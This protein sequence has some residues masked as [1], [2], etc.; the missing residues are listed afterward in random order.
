M[1]ARSES[2]PRPAESIWAALAVAALAVLAF[3][4]SWSLLHHGFYKHSN[5]IDTPIYQ[6]YGAAIAR[7]RVP[8]R[9]FQLEYPPGA[10]PVFVLPALGE[11]EQHDLDA[12]NHA[13][14][15]LMW[16]CG[17]AVLV[18]MAATLRAVRASLLRI[19]GALAFAAVAP[20]A[21][22]PVVLSRFDLWPAALTAGAIAA[23]VAGRRLLALLML[24]LATTAKLYPAVLLP[25]ALVHVW[26][27][28][29]ARAAAGAATAFAAAI[30]AVSAPFVALSPGGVWHSVTAQ[31]SRPLQIESLGSS[32]LLAAHQVAGV[33]LTMVSSYGSQNLA[34]SLPDAF[35]SAQA[36]LLVV[37][38]LALWIAFARGPAD[39]E[40]FLR[41]AAASVCAFVALAKVL[42]P[43]FVI[44]L[45]PLVPLVRGR[46]GLAAT[47]LLGAALVSTQLWFPY[48]YWRL[49]LDFAAF[50]SWMVFARDL[51]LLA[52]LAVLTL[53][54]HR[55][56]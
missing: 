35:A 44:W 29:G 51:L 41:Y 46:R 16:L 36:A 5:I 8:Y 25:L 43:Q 20:L 3:K 53:P 27:R 21:L 26:R 32:L 52:L 48:R 42:S 34:G 24:G 17:A 45:I 31:T 37:V 14:A 9:D 11:K 28:E 19:T 38:L 22:G 1:I 39:R 33:D 12:Y 23:L 40:R 15:R 56:A 18:L 10:L 55:H 54:R 7:D 47:A 13:F 4:G 6:T 2:W 30:V 49:A 50:P